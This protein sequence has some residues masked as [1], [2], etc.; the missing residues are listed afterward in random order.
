YTNGSSACIS[1]S[2]S[3]V[4]SRSSFQDGLGTHGSGSGLCQ[5]ITAIMLNQSLLSPLKLEA[6][7]NIQ[8]MC[9]QEKVQI[10][11]FNNKFVSFIDKVLPQ[12]QHNRRSSGASCYRKLI[13]SVCPSKQVDEINFLKHLYQAI[14]LQSQIL[15]TPVMWSVNNSCFLDMDGIITKVHAQYGEVTNHSR[16]AESMHLIKYEVQV[17]AGKYRRMEIFNMN[18]NISWLQAEDLKGQRASLEP[19]T[20]DAK[21]H[22][23]LAS[24]DTNTKLVELE[25]TLQGATQLPGTDEHLASPRYDAYHLLEG[26]DCQLESG[27]QNMSIHTK[28]IS[29]HSGGLNYGLSSFQLNFGSTG[30]SNNSATPAPQLAIVEKKIETHHGKLTAQTSDVLSK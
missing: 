15:D 16:K 23:E 9:T 24:K 18:W 17:L 19:T 13:S 2:F 25:T 27:M 1:S 6:D 8:A 10:K 12:E 21:L 20:E 29:G 14:I 5:G 30:G 7:P 4:G 28:A 22:G 26:K 3:W 11:T